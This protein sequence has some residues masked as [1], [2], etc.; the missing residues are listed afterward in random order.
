M[1][2]RSVRVDFFGGCREGG[3]S[4]PYA[5]DG[6]FDVVVEGAVASCSRTLDDFSNEKSASHRSVDKFRV[7]AG[8]SRGELSQ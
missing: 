7:T 3:C 4:R 8:H 2:K 6:E 5:S 1:S